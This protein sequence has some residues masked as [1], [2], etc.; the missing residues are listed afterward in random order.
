MNV[1]IVDNHDS[2][3]FNLFDLVGQVTG[4]APTVVTNDGVSLEELRRMAPAAV[5][6]SPGPGPPGRDRDFGICTDVITRLGVPVLG[7]CLGHQGIGHAFG[8]AVGHAPEPVHGRTSEVFHDGLDVFT[9]IPSGFR[10]VRYHSLTLAGDVPEELVVSAWT[11]DGLPMA[12]RHRSLP[13]RGVQFHPESVLSEHG[14]RLVRNFLDLAAPARRPVNGSPALVPRPSRDRFPSPPPGPW[15]ARSRRLPSWVEPEAAFCATYAGAPHAFWL[16][17]SLVGPGSSRFSFMGSAAGPEAFVLTYDS[18]DQVVTVDRDGEHGS[19]PVGIFEYLGRLLAERECPPPA[20]V[21]F[22]LNGGVVGWL[23]YELKRECGYTARH[24]SPLPDAAFLFADRIVAFDHEESAVHLVALE[25]DDG[26]SQTDRWF[27]ATEAALRCVPGPPPVT[28]ASSGGS[29]S[30]TPRRD[31]PGYVA[32]IRRCLDEIRDGES[33]EVCLTN[34]FTAD[35]VDRPLDL[36]R[37]LR[38]T[39]PAPYAA[40]L[41]FGDVAVL[42]SSPERLLRVERD[43]TVSSKPVKGT[44]ARAADRARD[45]EERRALAASAKEAAENLMIVDLVRNDLSRV[46]EVGSVRV[47]KLMDVETYDTVHHLVSTVSG[48]RRPGVTAIDCVRAVFPGGSMTGAPKARTI[49]I[50][51]RLER[52]ARGI[53]SGS[54]GWLAVSGAADLNVVI[55]TAVVTP[56]ETSFGAGGAITALSDA[57]GELEE[58][59][60][61]TAAIVRALGHLRRRE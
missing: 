32:D 42:S 60:L 3:T 1:V 47:P 7:V 20:G 13:L 16:D 29:L 33:Y 2:F 11:H 35:P 37:V 55:R 50:L 23:G 12:V 9:G 8:A 34:S 21:P 22:E 54:I 30:I 5:I 51:D 43:G 10:A 39:S 45:E 56:A 26:R 59:L 25:R 46:C 15:R 27:D 28:P 40:Y 38:Q 19:E 52:G 53:Y 4:V 24:R 6:I 14:H 44:A 17:S 49:E 18:E 36:Y 58:C 57:E 48:R 31:G 41:R 61:K